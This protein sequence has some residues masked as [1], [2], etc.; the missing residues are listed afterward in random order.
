MLFNNREKPK[1][2]VLEELDKEIL[3]CLENMKVTCND[4]PEYEAMARNLKQLYKARN[5]YKNHQN[6]DRAN[7]RGTEL[8]KILA[9]CGTG[10]LQVVLMMMFESYGNI[11]TTRALGML[12][13]PKIL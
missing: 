3:R 7:D 1:D 12:F 2:P 6:D 5:C 11:F 8:L 4:S 13:K 10:I 9:P